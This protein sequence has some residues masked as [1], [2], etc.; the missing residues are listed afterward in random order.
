MLGVLAEILALRDL[1][2][3]LPVFAVHGNH[4]VLEI[5]QRVH[6]GWCVL[7]G[8]LFTNFAFQVKVLI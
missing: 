4:E 1:E 3:P 7:L 2:G 6:I 8:Q 5:V